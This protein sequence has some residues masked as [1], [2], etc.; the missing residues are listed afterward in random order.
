MT[1]AELVIEVLPGLTGPPPLVLVLALLTECRGVVAVLA[2]VDGVFGVPAA[3][4]F[5]VLCGAI[6]DSTTPVTVVGAR[7]S[8]STRAASREGVCVRDVADVGA[9]DGLAV[10]L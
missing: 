2:D 9:M 3:D 8:G 6:V 1:V 5:G 10:R 4:T 7:L